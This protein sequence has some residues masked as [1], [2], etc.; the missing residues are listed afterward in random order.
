M[1]RGVPKLLSRGLHI[2]T[3][4]GTI[5]YVTITASLRPC[6]PQIASG[7]ILLIQHIRRGRPFLLVLTGL[8]L[9]EIN[10]TMENRH[11]L[12]HFANGVIIDAIVQSV[13]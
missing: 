4:V 13:E 5:W 6:D 11:G 12:Q 8:C 10:I 9:C 1:D 3:F 7:T 2:Y